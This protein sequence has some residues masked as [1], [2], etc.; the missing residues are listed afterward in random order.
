MYYYNIQS[1]QWYTQVTAGDRQTLEKKRQS[2]NTYTEKKVHMRLSLFGICI[3]V[4]RGAAG[5]VFLGVSSTLMVVF[6][7]YY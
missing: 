1:C 6:I 5:L 4:Q 3:L 7:Y 2:K